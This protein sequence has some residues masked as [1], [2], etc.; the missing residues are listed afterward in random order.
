MLSKGWGVVLNKKHQQHNVGHSSGGCSPKIYII[1][2][3]VL[4]IKQQQQRR[5]KKR[6]FVIMQ[7]RNHTNNKETRR[8]DLYLV[9]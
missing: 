3:I 2:Y 1:T 7:N 5:R 8:K 4:V 9:T 6:H